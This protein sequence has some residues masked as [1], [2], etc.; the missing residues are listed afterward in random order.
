MNRTLNTILIN[1]KVAGIITRK[2]LMAFN[3]EEKL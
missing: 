3:I 1:R 2:D